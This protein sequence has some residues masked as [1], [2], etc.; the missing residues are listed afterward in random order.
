M[1]YCSRLEPFG[2]APLEANAC[3][4]PVVAV[5]EG[6]VRETVVD[7][8]NGLLVDNDPRAAAAAVARLLDDP[9][10]AR[11]MGQSARREVAGKWSVAASVE[12]LERKLLDAVDGRRAEGSQAAGVGVS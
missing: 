11:R 5:A 7:G 6:G 2:F 8:V 12:R 1:L 9:E 10:Y 3:G 4:V